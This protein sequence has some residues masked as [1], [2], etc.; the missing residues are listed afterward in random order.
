MDKDLQLDQ[1]PHEVYN[2]EARPLEQSGE[3]MPGTKKV[4][5]ENHSRQ[6]RTR[7]G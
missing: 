2:N 1:N 6:I 5:Q 7:E 3:P 4:K